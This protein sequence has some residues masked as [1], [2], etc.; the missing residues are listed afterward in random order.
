MTQPRKVLLLT[1]TCGSGKSTVADLIAL[2]AGWQRISEDEIWRRHFGKE[3][4]AFGTNEYRRR[5][6]VVHQQVLDRTR[7]ALAGGYSVV[8]DATIHE[9]PP[10][11]LEEYRT[12]FAEAGISWSLCVLHPRLE[13]AIARDADRVDGSLGAARVAS[14]FAK[15]TRRIIPADCFLDT[16]DESPDV[17]VSR[18]LTMLADRALQ[19]PGGASP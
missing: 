14:L 3:R 19:Q 18:I 9:T 16:S 5:R 15:F 12:M 8:V 4:G 7:A 1:G 6:A 2:Q 10:E 17:T 13:I 11:A